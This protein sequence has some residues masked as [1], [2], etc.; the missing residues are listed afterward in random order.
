[1]NYCQEFYAE[2]VGLNPLEVFRRLNGASNAP[3]H[4]ILSMEI[5][6]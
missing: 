6:I 5:D 4:V 1:M 3:F 2:K